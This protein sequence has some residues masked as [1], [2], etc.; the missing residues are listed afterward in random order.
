[1]KRIAIGLVALF[2]LAAALTIVSCHTKQEASD[3]DQYRPVIRDGYH[4]FDPQTLRLGVT[5][6]QG[7][8]IL[9]KPYELSKRVIE[10]LVFEVWVQH[11]DA[12][13]T[14]SDPYGSNQIAR[15][16]GGFQDPDFGN[17]DYQ[18]R[19]EHYLGAFP[20]RGWAHTVGP[21]NGNLTRDSY[22]PGEVFYGIGFSGELSDTGPGFTG[23]MPDARAGDGIFTIRKDTR[24][25]PNTKTNP[26][27]PWKF[28]FWATDIRG[29]D[30]DP[31]WI[32]IKITE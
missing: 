30:S 26:D 2:V 23:N 25:D 8:T 17:E 16:S 12:A 21:I 7:E 1:M 14:D 5:V 11:P 20:D 22:L 3:P 4:R 13:G 9:R 24:L 32:E 15:V 28:Y 6:K 19:V 31:Y 18:R 27:R 29:N 10:P